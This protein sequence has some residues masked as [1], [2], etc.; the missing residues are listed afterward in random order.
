MT[1]HKTG[2]L[3]QFGAK[4]PYPKICHEEKFDS[5]CYHHNG[6]SFS[7]LSNFYPEN[8]FN[9]TY[10]GFVNS[11]T[12]FVTPVTPELLFN[13]TKPDMIGMFGQQ[14]HANWKKGT[15]MALGRKQVFKFMS[16]FSVIIK[17][18]HLIEMRQYMA[19]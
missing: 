19:N 10:V 15:L 4:Y 18:E 14:Q 6:N 11:D 8:C 17:V 9:K 7:E 5:K 3:V 13:G 1:L 16:Y 2:S 12:F